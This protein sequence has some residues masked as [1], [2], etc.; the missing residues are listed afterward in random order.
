MNILKDIYD[1]VSPRICM[2]CGNRLYRSE[3]YVCSLCLD[4][5]EGTRM[6]ESERSLMALT[7]Y[8]RM[9]IERAAAAYF[10]TDTSRKIVH[11]LKYFDRPDF[12]AYLMGRYVESLLGRT[13]FFGEI[14]MIIPVP[15]HWR[16]RLERGYNQ[17]LLLAREVG[18]R[19]GIPV[20]T[21]VVVRHV[22]TVKQAWMSQEEREENMRDVFR[23]RHPEELHGKHILIVDDVCTSGSTIVSLARELLQ[24]DDPQQ[25]H[26]IRISVLTLALATKDGVPATPKGYGVEELFP[27]FT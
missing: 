7:F 17:S 21:D 13:D 9:P 23:C 26:G 22:Y 24:S 11:N 15:I 4:N 18:R 10:F 14:D 2:A 27:F 25:W 16:R 8:G 6:E 12:A 3:H 19:T 1:F 5:L 20:R